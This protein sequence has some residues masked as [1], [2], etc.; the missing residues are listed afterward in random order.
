M[1]ALLIVLNLALALGALWGVSS[2]FK[3]EEKVVY[4]AGRERSE[5]RPESRS[6]IVGTTPKAITAE[7]AELMITRNNLFNINRC[8]DAVAGRG[9]RTANTQLALVGIYKVGPNQGAVIRQTRQARRNFFT[10]NN[11]NQQQQAAPQ[12]FFRIGDTLENGYTLKSVGSNSVTLSRSG[13]NMELQLESAG[14]NVTAAQASQQAAAQRPRNAAE[15][16]QMMMMGQMRM[17]QQM[18]MQQNRMV[19]QNATSGTRQQPR[20]RTSTRR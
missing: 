8:P 19:Q 7:D 10:R 9:G 6:K 16:Q 13:S 17:M 20:T 11:N 1:K 14:Q 2:L 18:M 5:S 3:T 12:Q 15:M 4:S